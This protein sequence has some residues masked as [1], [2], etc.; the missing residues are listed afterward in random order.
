VPTSVVLAS[1]AFCSTKC[2]VVSAE[3]NADRCSFSSIECS[4]PGFEWN[5]GNT[6]TA[7]W[8]RWRFAFL[9]AEPEPRYCSATRELTADGAIT[10]CSCPSGSE[11]SSN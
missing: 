7:T 9:T 8:L 6:R 11:L 5:V 1:T 10:S 3:M 2:S 4:R